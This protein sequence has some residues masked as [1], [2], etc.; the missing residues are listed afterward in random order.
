MKAEQ[1]N[2]RVHGP[3]WRTSRLV[4]HSQSWL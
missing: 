2:F 4:S 1:R 3:I